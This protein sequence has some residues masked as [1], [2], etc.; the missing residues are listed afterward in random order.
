MTSEW[1]EDR[2][3]Y[4]LPQFFTRMQSRTRGTC[5]DGHKE[6]PGAARVIRYRSAAARGARCALFDEDVRDAT[7]TTRSATDR[8][9][10]ALINGLLADR[11]TGEILP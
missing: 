3:R 6:P 2:H 10:L 4:G 9:S 1:L 7:S 5:E 11:M 8:P